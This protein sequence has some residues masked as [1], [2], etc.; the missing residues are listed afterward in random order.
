M[1]IEDSIVLA[2]ELARHDTPEAAFK[3]FHARRFERC[4]YIVDASRAI[5]FGQTGQ[6]PV[7]ENATATREM[8]ARISQPI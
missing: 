7:I 3:A 5:S 1:A 4:K 2:E 6:G 8:F